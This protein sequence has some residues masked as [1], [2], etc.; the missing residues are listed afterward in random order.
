[1]K[2]LSL[3]GSTACGRR[4]AR[5][6]ARCT[7]SIA[8]RAAD[9]EP[10][11][12]HVKENRLNS[13]A[14]PLVVLAASNPLLSLLEPQAKY[15]ATL[16]LPDWL[17]H[18]GHPGNMTVVL[19]AMGGYGAGYLG[20]QIRLAGNA[21]AREAA[22][23]AHPKIAA[24]MAIFF[25]L[26][27]LGG[28]ESLVMQ[29]KDIMASPHFITGSLGLLLLGAQAMLPLFF[30]EDPSV[31]TVHAYLGSGILALFLAHAALGLQLGLSI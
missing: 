22:K 9:K 2:A 14:L 16:G 3:A 8:C 15:F 13:T 28:M 10:Q 11:E 7:P 20:W 6:S 23:A 21:G 18:W 26:G 29:G 31:R 12:Q 5:A 1:M 17:V 19:L 25:A 30:R 27:A 24:G 4:C